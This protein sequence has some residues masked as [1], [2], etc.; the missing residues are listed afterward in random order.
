MGCRL[1]LDTH[2]K[3]IAMRIMVSS[4]V[5]FVQR[6]EHAIPMRVS[7][8][9]TTNYLGNGISLDLYSNA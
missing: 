7:L 4:L 2:S 6:A 5:L 3:S 1:C 9:D 8:M